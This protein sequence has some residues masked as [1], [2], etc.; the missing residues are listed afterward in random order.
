MNK[1]FKVFVELYDLVITTRK[2]DRS[3]RVVSTGTLSIADIIEIAKTRRSDISPEVML[4][5]Y[6]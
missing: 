5:V 3:G 2:D 4:A 6:H 1:I